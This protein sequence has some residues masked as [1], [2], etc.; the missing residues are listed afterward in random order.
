MNTSW[1]SDLDSNNKL[2]SEKN[3]FAMALER[4][5][6][7]VL[8]LTDYVA[9]RWYRAPEILLGSLE[10][11]TSSDIWS[12]GCIFGE[13]L[14]GRVIFPGT[15]TLNQLERIFEAVGR[16]NEQDLKDINSPTSKTLIS[17]VEIKHQISIEKLF[18]GHHEVVTDLYLD[19]NLNTSRHDHFEP[20]EENICQRW[21]DAPVY[22]IPSSRRARPA[23]SIL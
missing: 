2:V 23:D 18:E 8:N 3:K 19:N 9:S 10:Y 7:E 17:A 4:Q 20:K 15:S 21:L 5:D 13:M 1:K 6:K 22:F 11:S 14:L 16:P 12:L